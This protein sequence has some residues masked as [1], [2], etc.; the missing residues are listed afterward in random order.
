[1]GTFY[2]S[3]YSSLSNMYTILLNNPREY[4]L[5]FVAEIISSH[6]DVQNAMKTLDFNTMSN[7]NG[8]WKTNN[9][10]YPTLLKKYYDESKKNF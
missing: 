5:F 1:M 6:K 2:K 9:P 4:V 7:Y 10:T 8:A 3:R